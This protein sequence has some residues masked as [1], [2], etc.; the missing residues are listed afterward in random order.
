MKIR[1]LILDNVTSYEDPVEFIFDDGL[2]ILIGPNGGGKSNLQKTIA[3]ILTHYFIHQWQVKTDDDRSFFEKTQIYKKQQ[4]RSL[5][6]TYAGS[7]KTQV[8]E[9]EL[10]PEARDIENIKV[11]GK[12]LEEINSALR[13]FEK[14]YETY[15]PLDFL[16]QIER[17][18]SFS[19]RIVDRELEMPKKGTGAYAFL[20]YLNDFFIFMSSFSE[21]YLSS[22]RK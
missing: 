9:I 20:R 16:S 15:E 19:Y 1:R 5:L 6:S 4:L 8:I 18:D 3:I 10:I 13:T 2:N 11:I 17:A 14:P 7:D 22:N 21:N 12:N